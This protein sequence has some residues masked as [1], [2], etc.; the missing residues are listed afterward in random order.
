M[1]KI[2]TRSLSIFIDGAARGNPGPSGIGVVIRDAQGI[3]IDNLSKYIGNATNNVAEYS[4]LIFGMDGARKL[5]AEELVINTDSEL[6]AK[7]LGGEYKIKNAALK[8][9][10]SE[11]VELLGSFSEVKVNQISREE[12][13]AADKLANKAIDSAKKK[14]VGKSFMLKSRINK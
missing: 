6:L 7:Q 8:D 9:L 14:K 3:T 4:A 5:G 11:V 1:S 13:K 12:N 10:Y 2:N